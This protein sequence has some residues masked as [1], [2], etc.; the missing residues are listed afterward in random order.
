MRSASR[1]RLNQRPPFLPLPFKVSPGRSMGRVWAFRYPFHPQPVTI[2][3]PSS[4]LEGKGKAPT[5][6]IGYL[7]PNATARTLQSGAQKK[8][9]KKMK[10]KR[11]SKKRIFKIW[12]PLVTCQPL[13]FTPK[14]TVT[15]G[16]P[17]TTA[18]PRL[19][20]S[21]C[22]TAY[23]AWQPHRACHVGPTLPAQ[24]ASSALTSSSPQKKGLSISF[25]FQ[26]L[27]F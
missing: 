1:P 5:A 8:G 19:V 18:T 20:V 26:K 23:L 21:L 3:E 17:T 6:V 16:P 12:G 27:K 25:D 9:R 2:P 7:S 13:L 15:V 10:R 24:P 14:K 11:K 4:D 22:R